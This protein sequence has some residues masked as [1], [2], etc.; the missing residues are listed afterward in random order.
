MRRPLLI[1]SLL[2]AL[3]LLRAQG[4]QD[5]VRML[6]EDYISHNET[7]N[8]DAELLFELLYELHEHPV[9][10]NTASYDDLSR[11]PFLS[12]H[13]INAL[14]DYVQTH[15]DM[16]SVYEL[17]AVYGFDRVTI[18]NV[19]PFVVLSESND[20]YKRS[21][22]SNHEVLMRSVTVLENQ[23]GYERP[24]SMNHYKG[25]PYSALLKY[26][27]SL[28]KQFSWH[29]TGEQ[30]RG[31][32]WFEHAP[33]TDFFSAG[34]QYQGDGLVRNVIVGDYRMC[35]GQGL[36]VNNNFGYGK[37]SQV[38]DVTQKGAPL[39]RFTSSSE[40]GMFRGVA[41]HFNI[42]GLDII[43]GYSLRQAD[44]AL[45]SIAGKRVIRS[46]PQTG[47]HRTNSEIAKYRSAQVNDVIARLAY[48][49]HNLNIGASFI[50]QQLSHQYLETPRWDNYFTPSYTEYYN[51]SI[52]YKWNF[53]GMM[54]FG[55]IA[56][57]QQQGLAFIQGV[58]LYPSSRVGVSLLYR[59]YGKDYYS[60][61]GQAFGEGSRVSNEEGLYMGV[62]VLL[63]KSWTLN[64]YGDWYRFPWLR[65]G[66][67]RPATGYDVLVQ[68][69]YSPTKTTQM[70]WRIKYEEKEEAEQLN[71]PA[72]GLRNSQRLNARYH[73]SSRLTDVFSI[74]S[75]LATTHVLHKNDE[76]GFLIYQDLTAKLLDQKLAMT[77][78]YALFNTTSYD[79]RIYTYESDVLYLSSTPA[80]YGNGS[81]TYLN[82]SY[83]MNDTFTFYLKAS[84]SKNYDDRDM[85][86][87]LDL[88]A[89]DHKTDI[90]FQVR[91]KL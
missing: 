68:P 82:A 2:F 21:L 45:D 70:H 53:R 58:S 62:N 74:Q 78:R 7:A 64:M 31:E 50:A 73:I 44:A 5:R 86:S 55:E 33:V 34:V 35:F 32:P 19:L 59:N 61:Y 9:N 88:I 29:V 40:F 81:R 30:D 77:L 54:L 46:F 23:L 6:V 60:L 84:F 12:P 42:K 3:S 16:M 24:D 37:S 1:I 36:A 80:F 13:Q 48:R 11:L 51:T 4:V 63:S 65:Y 10:I 26:K 20:I 52:D 47:F 69:T 18:E 8:V 22:Y 67:A 91:I 87:G 41:T 72:Y 17:Q 28:G 39:R 38:M 27:G 79:S 90:H 14:L 66:V 56:T 89:T 49:I 43:A 76:R 71:V 15:G 75:R 83:K 57:D 85:G 25:S